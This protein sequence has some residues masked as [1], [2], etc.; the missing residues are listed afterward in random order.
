MDVGGIVQEF[1]I[2]PIWE[3]TGY[4]TVNTFTYAIIALVVLFVIWKIFEIKKVKID[5]SFWA[6]AIVWTVFGSSL[7]VITDAV[8]SGVMMNKYIA[9][10]ASGGNGI[11]GNIGDVANAGGIGFFDGIIN[12]IY[13][14][15]LGSGAFDYGIITV[16]PGVY[17]V[18]AILFLLSVII[19]RKIKIKFWAAGVGGM[20]AI[21]NLLVLL[22]LMQYFAYGIMV[23]GVALVATVAV[24][25]FV[26]FRGREKR[27]PVFGHALDGAATWIAIDFFGSGKG[28]G[29]FEQ[30]VLSRGIGEATGLGFG[31]FFA[32][33]VLFAGAAVWLL[34][35][36]KDER[37]R[38]MA[39]L[40][41][42]IIGLAPGLRD[43]LRMMAGT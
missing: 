4:N 23:V 36:E 31:L 20:F 28:A 16:S 26:N 38:G 8:D 21:I 27:L 10:A 15:V 17:V 13:G 5:E 2:S 25:Y 29:Y 9:T 33:K 40:A 7:R 39:L 35:E 22:P 42:A 34:S 30:H 24:S 18:T 11:A 12:A 37:M 41:I 32:V 14:M 3:K 1:F 43:L 19:E 6:G